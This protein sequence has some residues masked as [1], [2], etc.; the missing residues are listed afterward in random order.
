M[1]RKLSKLFEIKLLLRQFYSQSSSK[2]WL[3]CGVKYSSVFSS[4]TKI[5]EEDYK[6]LIHIR[7]RTNLTALTST[8]SWQSLIQ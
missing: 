8:P 3:Y 5:S 4:G 1:K 2:S 6:T 7:K